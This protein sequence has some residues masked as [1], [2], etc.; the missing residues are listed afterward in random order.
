MNDSEIIRKLKSREEE[1]LRQLIRQYNSYVTAI[2]CN[3]SRGILSVEDI[4]E[5]AADVFLSIWN[6]SAGLQDDRP[7]KPYLAQTARN[8]AYSRLRK[9]KELPV[10]YDD[11]ILPLSPVGNPDELTIRREQTEIINSAVEGFGE[12]D[13][14]IFIRFYYLG[15]RI[16]A[17][18]RR[19]TLNPSTVKTRL[20][21]CR[22]RL[23]GIFEERGY[24][25]G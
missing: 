1:G 8:A 7:V 5:L 23:K 15:E 14:E 19:L 10:A 2:L 16:E 24:R 21:R 6:H 11:D 17:I 4:E 20:H 3:I 18:G 22:K 25:H 9:V 12:P 13:R